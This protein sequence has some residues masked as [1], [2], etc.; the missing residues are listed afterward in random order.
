MGVVSWVAE[1]VLRVDLFFRGE[2]NVYATCTKPAAGVGLIKLVFLVVC[3]FCLLVF[4]FLGGGGG[5][6]LHV[7]S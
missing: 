7:I 5:C 2:V 3:V 1:K 6:A 4:F